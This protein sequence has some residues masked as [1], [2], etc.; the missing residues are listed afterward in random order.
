MEEITKLSGAD[1]MAGLIGIGNSTGTS[2]LLGV[3]IRF[4]SQA[5]ATEAHE[6]VVELLPT[7]IWPAFDVG[8]IPEKLCQDN[9]CPASRFARITS[10]VEEPGPQAGVHV[11]LVPDNPPP[12]SLLS[13]SG[14]K[15]PADV[16]PTHS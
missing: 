3:Q 15:A 6:A 5:K 1:D 14:K 12:L 13:L 7:S 9:Q 10:E 2:Q 8:Y 11:L 4:A 16:P